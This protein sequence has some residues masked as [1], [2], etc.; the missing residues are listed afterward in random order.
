MLDLAARVAA[1]EKVVQRYRNRA[2]AWH[3]R[4][5]CLHLVR[6][7]LLALGHRP[8]RIPDIRSAQGAALAM[9]RLGFQ[10]VKD[11][12]DSLLP[13]IAP[14][15]MM[16]GDIGLLPGEPPFEAAV[17]CLGGSKVAGWHGSDLSALRV[18]E[19]TRGDFLAAYRT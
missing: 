5:T 6:G 14:L 13:P 9:K 11:V 19:V 18:I 3:D 8:P 2:F 1:T 15:A 17:I 10:S 7:Q 4:A 16:V 12:L